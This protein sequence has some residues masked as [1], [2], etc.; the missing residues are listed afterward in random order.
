MVAHDAEC[1]YLKPY[2][3][4]HADGIDMLATMVSPFAER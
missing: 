4:I 2:C 1:E 3:E